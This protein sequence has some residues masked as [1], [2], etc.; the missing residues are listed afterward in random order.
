[1]SL[2]TARGLLARIM[3]E[4]YVLPLSSIQKVVTVNS[5]DVHTVGG[6]E[7]IAVNGRQTALISLATVLERPIIHSNPLDTAPAVVL[8][9][10]ATQAAFV[11][12]ELLG[13]QEMI[14]KGLGAQLM[15]VRNVAGAT[16]LGNGRV[17]MILNPAEM[18]RSIQHDGAR[19]LPA[20]AAP[21]AES[22]TLPTILVVDDS[23]TTRTLEKNILEAAGY[24]VITAVNGI[25]AL[26][27]LSSDDCNLVVADVQMPRMNGFE[28]TQ[29][30]KGHE[31]F[32]HLPVILVTSLES[33]EDRSQGMTAGADAYIVKSAFDQEDLLSTIR[34]ML[35]EA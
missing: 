2:A 24:R 16:L 31:E 17:V 15:H 13:E 28:L 8:Q 1:V 27:Y 23:I 32:G 30:I 9:V 6:R 3:D 20:F 34:Q 19:S 26:G 12:D 22:P 4:V 5:A 29:T 7:M 14:V 33:Q 35:S 25:E 21:L 11:V 18:I 10:G